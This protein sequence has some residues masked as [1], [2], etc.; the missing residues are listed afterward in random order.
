MKK[1]RDALKRNKTLKPYL[2]LFFL[3]NMAYIIFAGV[4]SRYI[5]E[6][7]L[8]ETIDQVQFEYLS[9][10]SK[11]TGLL[12]IFVIV[13]LMGYLIKSTM[14][15]EK[16]N[17]KHFLI[18]HVMLF[19]TLLFLNFVVSAFSPAN[20]WASSQLLLFPIQIIIIIL[21]YFIGVSLYERIFR[22]YKTLKE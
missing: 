11:I 1:L 13:I 14:N 10:I 21:I 16:D 8:S 9:N 15:K 5:H 4:K 17:L 22:N 18:I 3:I 6:N 12:E 20:F 19:A 7:S 2:L